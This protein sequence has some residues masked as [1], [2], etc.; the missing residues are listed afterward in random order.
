MVDGWAGAQYFLRPG[1]LF[2]T[3]CNLAVF[4]CCGKVRV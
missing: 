2:S 1:L 3:S 4:I